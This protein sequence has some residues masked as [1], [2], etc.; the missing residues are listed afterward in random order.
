LRAWCDPKTPEGAFVWIVS[1]IDHKVRR[2]SPKN[3]FVE[4]DFYTIYNP[5][6]NGAVILEH[7]LKRIEDKFIRL[8]PK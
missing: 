5:E 3:L 6:G 7:E 2:K 1:K 8:Y 4:D